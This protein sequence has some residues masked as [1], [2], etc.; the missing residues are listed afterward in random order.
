[1]FR[2]AFLSLVFILGPSTTQAFCL[3][4]LLHLPSQWLHKPLVPSARSEMTA[5]IEALLPSNPFVISKSEAHQIQNALGLTADELLVELLPIAQKYARPPISKYYVGEALRTKQGEI[6]LGVNLEFPGQSLGLTVHGEQF[7]LAMLFHK[8][9]REIDAW[10][11]SGEPCGHCRQFMNEV[12]GIEDVKILI[13]QKRATSLSVLLPHSFGPRNLGS[14]QGLLDQRVAPIIPRS[15]DLLK[16]DE[17]FLLA[18]DAAEL[19]YAPY[20]KN[21]SGVGVRLK[22]GKRYL[23]SYLENVAFNPSLTPLLSAIV[24]MIAAGDRPEDIEAI[25]LAERTNA[26]SSSQLR[27]TRDI[28]DSLGLKGIEIQYL[29]LDFKES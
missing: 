26:E 2:I 15:E 4:S 23:G 29:P 25:V 11:L 7:L 10:A 6:Y 27:V 3:K 16:K 28:L 24:Q 1:M 21:Y 19:S 22:N 14:P 5:K 8:N 13:P 9:I 20:S 18:Y 17:L 12:L